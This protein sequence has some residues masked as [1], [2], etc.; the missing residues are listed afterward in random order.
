MVP[1][2]GSYDPQKVKATQK[3]TGNIVF[4]KDERGTLKPTGIPGPGAYKK[5][6][7]LKQ[8]GGFS[9]P[10]KNLINDDKRV[11]GPGTYESKGF[12]QSQKNGPGW[13]MGTDRKDVVDRTTRKSVPGS[14]SYNIEQKHSK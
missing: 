14:G 4:G 13:G 6:E 3:T 11:P 8:N 10:G 7:G 2:A 12:K 1:G 9:M 5:K